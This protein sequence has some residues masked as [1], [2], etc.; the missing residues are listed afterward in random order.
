MV[1][2][3]VVFPQEVPRRSWQVLPVLATTPPLASESF[4]SPPFIYYGGMTDDEEAALE[5]PLPSRARVVA[6]FGADAASPR[7]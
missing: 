1:Q 4:F 3:C 5:D 6:G 7:T 2:W